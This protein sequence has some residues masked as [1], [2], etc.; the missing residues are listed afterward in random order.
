MRTIF[1]TGFPGFLASALIP[2]LVQRKASPR[3]VDCIVLPHL[4]DSAHQRAQEISTKADC[5]I[6]VF[7]GDIT[8]IR[9]GMGNEYGVVTKECS[10]IFH[11][12]AIYDLAVAK[13]VAERVNVD[14]TR[15]V[16]AFATDCPELDRF[17]HISTCYVSGRFD[18]VFRENDLQTGQAFSNHYESTKFESEVLV[19]DAASSGLP[20][21][22][23]R[24]SI[25]SGDSHTGRTQKMDGPYFFVQ[26]M[27]AQPRIAVM[28]VFAG[29]R[30][31]TMNIV[32]SDYITAAIATLST[33]RDRPLRVYSLADPSPLT[34]P[35]L[36]QLLAHATGRRVLRVP[37]TRWLA[38]ALIRSVSHLHP[39]MDIPGEAV[40]YLAHPTHYDCSNTLQDLEGSGVACPPFAEY[41][42]RLVGFVRDES[43]FGRRRL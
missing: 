21:T 31:A 5:E 38:S 9:L 11:L 33:G 37:A 24:P 43:G 36:T 19:H 3:R 34:I 22:I 41:V 12:A 17:H 27:L 13:D 15:N 4:L 14:G 29:S 16:L 32:P 25:V 40:N 30:E 28:P 6:R 10:E 39:D 23:Y 42:D 8:D 26:W 20:T 7:A 18:G 2:T 1:V 35:A